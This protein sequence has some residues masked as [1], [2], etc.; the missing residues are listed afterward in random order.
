M[1]SRIL[2]PVDGSHTSEFGLKE[3]VSIAKVN[4]SEVLLVHV[5]NEFVFDYSY[6]AG[7]YSSDLVD[8]LREGGKK[9]LDEAQAVARQAGIAPARVMLETLGGGA[10]GLIVEQAREWRADLIVMGTHGRRGLARL[11][12]GSDAE[13]VVRTAGIPVLLVRGPD[14]AAAMTLNVRRHD[15][16]PTPT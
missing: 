13:E 6:M 8:S 10:A 3:A 5:V 11:A 1:Y 12:M 14:H 7:M 15:P 2:V 9:I 4:G 16:A